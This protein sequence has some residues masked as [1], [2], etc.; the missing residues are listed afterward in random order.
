M[1]AV[2]SAVLLVRCDSSV[3]TVLLLVSLAINFS[4][5]VSFWS[6][7]VWYPLALF[8]G[9]SLNYSLFLAHVQHTLPVVLTF[10]D[11]SLVRHRTDERVVT[12]RRTFA[13]SVAIGI[14]YAARVLARGLRGGGWSYPFMEDLSFA[15]WLWVAGFQIVLMYIASAIG[16]VCASARGKWRLPGQGSARPR[17]T[18]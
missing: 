3:S 2:T 18:S 10:L 7:C 6:L 9:G 12:V 17:P 1:H 4:V 5:A 16:V 13:I 11:V 15:G 14:A 8:P